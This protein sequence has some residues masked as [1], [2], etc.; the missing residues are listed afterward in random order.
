MN[1]STL[2]ITSKLTGYRLFAVSSILTF[3]KAIVNIHTIR[4]HSVWMK[5]IPPNSAV[6]DLGANKGDFSKYFSEKRNCL[7]Y[8]VEPNP[9]LA[10]HISNILSVDV[11]NIAITDYPGEFEFRISENLEASSLFSEM[12]VAWGDTET[13]KVSGE[14]L[15][16][17]LK[18][19][20]IDKITLLK[21]DVEGAELGILNNLSFNILD[22]IDQMTVEFHDFLDPS[23]LPAVENAIKRLESLGF[24]C[25]NFDKPKHEDVM[26]IN[27]KLF[28]ER[29]YWLDY[30]LFKI[31]N[32]LLNLKCQDDAR[33]QS[34]RNSQ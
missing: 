20:K 34:S 9:Q 8:C 16:T 14:T 21:I 24:L 15:E 1:K 28:K 12:A 27:K 6:I 17:F 3:L 5:P 13:I 33:F 30:T 32:L 31:F 4:Y 2:N 22:K 19:K 26:F 29:L 7:V 11:S 10:E 23:L 18:D 25:I